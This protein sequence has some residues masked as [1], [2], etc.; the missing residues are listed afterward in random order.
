MQSENTAKTDSTS[1]GDVAE[2]AIVSL[3]SLTDLLAEPVAGDASTTPEGESAQ[4]DENGAAA[5]NGTE[6]P[7]PE[8]FNDLADSAGIELDDLY[9]LK[10][11]TV[12]GETVT[13][14]ELKSLQGKQDDIV[15]RELEFEET[16]S[17][18][19]GSLRQAQNE[20]AEIVKA[21]P[22]GTIKPAVLEKLRAKN[23]ARVEL[24]QTRMLDEIPTWSDEKSRTQDMVG[25]TAHLE[26]F[27]FPANYLQQVIDHRQMIFIRESFLREQRIKNALERV[28]A[29]APNPTTTTRTT[30]KPGGKTAGKAKADTRNGLEAF[31]S[32]V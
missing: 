11:T 13:I 18:K 21:L 22:D 7:K 19:E 5:G 25:M 6:K 23:T 32:D 27:G 31:F 24:E 15:L 9:K 26:R 8:M 17:K 4:A 3:E 10:V 29:G 12:N 20:L 28:R 30:G 16:R 2:P 14:E 1:E